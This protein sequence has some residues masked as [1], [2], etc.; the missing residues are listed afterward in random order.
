MR[1]AKRPFQELSPEEKL[2]FVE[3]YLDGMSQWGETSAQ[4]KDLEWLRHHIP[5]HKQDAGE[6]YVFISYSHRDYKQVYRDLAFFRYNPEKRVRFWYDEGLPAGKDWLDAAREHLCHPNCVGVIFYLSEAFLRSGAVL[7]EIELTES[8]GKPYLTVALE[9]DRFCAEDLLPQP[10]DAALRDRV[11]CVFSRDITALPYGEEYEEILYRIHKIE[12]TFSVT[13]NVYSD[14]ICEK[15][16]DGLRLTAYRG[17]RTDVYIPE[18]IGS[19]PVV[20]IAADLDRA[21]ML[22]IPASVRRILPVV[23]EDTSGQWLEDMD[24]A[25]LAGV[26]D[27]SVGGYQ[28]PGYLLGQGQALERIEVDPRNPVFFDRDGVLYGHDGTLVRFPPKHPWDNAFLEGVKTIGMSAFFGVNAGESVHIPAQV[29]QIGDHAFGSSSWGIF[30]MTE[31]QVKWIGASAFADCAA[32]LMPMILPE[33]LESLG[34]WAFRNSHFAA[35]FNDSDLKTIPRG[36]FCG[37]KGEFGDIFMSVETIG[38]GA[39]AFCDGLESIELPDGLQRIE[40]RAFFCC[41]QV[42]H[43]YLPASIRYLAS[44]VLEGCDGLRQILYQGDEMAFLQMQ[45]KSECM[46]PDTLRHVIYRNQTLRRLGAYIRRT[47]RKLAKKILEKM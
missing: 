3:A 4:A 1:S 10:E 35:I 11:A 47:L 34:D 6:N 37:F 16:D 36:A 27:Y 13:E 17:K 42:H 38:A 43:A 30:D 40:T 9:E 31:S 14:F 28:S 22:Y 41:N 15:V 44:G 7:Q 39:F 33:T 24:K 19:E 12:E 2:L 21:R 32:A 20:E 29:E 18:R 45:S 8:T 26:L 25:S 46:E 5:S 23:P